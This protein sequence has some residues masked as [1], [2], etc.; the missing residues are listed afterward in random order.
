MRGALEKQ[1]RTIVSQPLLHCCPGPEESCEAGDYPKRDWVL[2][3]ALAGR[4]TLGVHSQGFG[5]ARTLSVTLVSCL[6]WLLFPRGLDNEGDVA[7][8]VSETDQAVRCGFW[9]IELGT[10]DGCCLGLFAEGDSAQGHRDSKEKEP[11]LPSSLLFKPPMTVWEHTSDLFQAP[12]LAAM[13]A[14]V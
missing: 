11:S 14:S 8:G 3:P 7:G 9:F 6:D 12:S 2:F 4:C 13:W 1:R 5:G 10:V